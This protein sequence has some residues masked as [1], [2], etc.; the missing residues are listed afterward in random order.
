[1]CRIVVGRSLKLNSD[2]KRKLARW[3]NQSL[4]SRVE[5]F[6]LAADLSTVIRVGNRRNEGDPQ[7]EDDPRRRP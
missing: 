7:K 6:C 1:M 3:G 2:K 4:P 5:Q